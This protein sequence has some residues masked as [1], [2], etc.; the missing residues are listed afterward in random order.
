MANTSVLDENGKIRIEMETEGSSVL[1]R[2]IGIIDEDVNF[3][4]VLDTISKM[5]PLVKLLQLDMSQVSRMN[6]CGVR[7]WILMMERMPA[8]IPVAFVNANELFVEQANMIPGM[9]GRKGMVKVLNFQAPYHCSKCDSDET[10]Q[11]EPKDVK[12][13]GDQPIA[14]AFNCKGCGGKLDFDWIEEEYFGF[15]T[16]L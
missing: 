7:E 10:L 3:S 5:Q 8:V 9:F 15:I 1:I 4:I 13:D 12:F 11:M 2:P 6:S 16:R 14:P